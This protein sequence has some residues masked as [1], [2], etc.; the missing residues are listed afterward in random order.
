[1]AWDASACLSSARVSNFVPTRNGCP[2]LGSFSM[3]V[4]NWKA[5]RSWITC[6]QGWIRDEIGGADVDF[7]QRL[8]AIGI[9]IKNRKLGLK[10]EF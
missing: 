5:T 6:V 9:S 2:A 8:A 3:V 10:V 1:M 7:S 4:I